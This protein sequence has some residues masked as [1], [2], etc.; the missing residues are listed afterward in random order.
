MTI[1]TEGLV[2]ILGSD[3]SN[4]LESIPSFAGKLGQGQDS[5][6]R[7]SLCLR[8]KMESYL[9]S[10]PRVRQRFSGTPVPRKAKNLMQN[11]AAFAQQ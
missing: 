5:C 10:V 11:K 7:S 2:G 9:T 8:T 3:G 6:P 1:G 4:Y